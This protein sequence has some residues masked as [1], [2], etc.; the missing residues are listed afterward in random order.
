[1]GAVVPSIRN[2]VI[3]I[4]VLAPISVIFLRYAV[5]RAKRDGNL[6]QY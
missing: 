1:V 3:F 2:L 5:N 4:V 6:V